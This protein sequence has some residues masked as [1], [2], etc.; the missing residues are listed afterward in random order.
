MLRVSRSMSTV[1]RATM[2][3]LGAALLAVPALRAQ[4]GSRNDAEFLLKAFDTYRAML[5]SSPYKAIPWQA[6]GPTNISGRAT[7]IAV[8]NRAGA[9]R[10]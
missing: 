10:N 8:A 2:V 9:R 6:L 3:L 1:R 7:D 5:E 4:S